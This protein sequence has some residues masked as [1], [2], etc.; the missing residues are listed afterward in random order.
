MEYY[1]LIPLYGG[2]LFVACTWIWLLV[3]AFRESIWWG[4]GSLFLPP[5]ALWFA[6]RY[7]QQTVMPLIVLVAGGVVVIGSALYLLAVPASV[8]SHKDSGQESRLW[9][10]TSGALHSDVVHEWVESRAYFL[11]VGAVPV[12]V[13]GWIWLLA[14]AFR[15][16]R[17]WGW[18]SLFLP[19]AGLAFAARHPRR[20]AAPLILVIL[21]ALVAAV[22]AVYILCVQVDLGPRDKNVNGERHVTLTG[23]D[24]NDYSILKLMPDVSV[25]QMANADVTDQVLESLHSMKNL[26]ELDLNGTQVTD[27]GLEIIRDLPLLATLRLART[28]V[29]DQGFRNALSTKDSLMQLDLQHTQV[30]RDTVKAWRT[31]KPDRKAMQ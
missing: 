20:G 12:I 1:L 19:P 25:L 15:Q 28:K 14:R 5:L 2:L 22:P 23:W 13:C 8:T 27:A 18:S 16:R 24:R 6:A 31:A 11:Q 30:S 9:S 21:A 3:C 29:T 7:P 4:L 10:L 17:A 26:R